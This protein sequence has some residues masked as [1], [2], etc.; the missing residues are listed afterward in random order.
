MITRIFIAAALVLSC[1]LCLAEDFPQNTYEIKSLTAEQATDLVANHHGHLRLSGLTSIDKDVARELAK[2]SGVWV[3]E[4]RPR[5]Y[6]DGALVF[7]SEKA[8]LLLDGLTSINKEVAQELAKYK[9]K[10]LFLDGL[11]S[12][13]KDVAQELA[14]FKGGLWLLGLTSIDKDVA[15]EL[16]KFKGERLYLVSCKKNG[17]PPEYTTRKLTVTKDTWDTLKSYPKIMMPNNVLPI[18]YGGPKKSSNE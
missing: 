7:Q 16:G 2:Y 6:K 17:D 5:I 18:N 14:K 11:T 15:Q 12:I 1:G 9:G 13:D 3:F 8:C 10:Y 4:D